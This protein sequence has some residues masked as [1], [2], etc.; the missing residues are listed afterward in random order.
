[1]PG[2][3]PWAPT[4]ALTPGHTY[5]WWVRGLSNSNVSSS[6]SSATVF[7]V[8]LL[9][10]PGLVSP[11]GSTT[12]IGVTFTWNGVGS[13]SHYYLWVQDAASGK[14]IV[15]NPNVTDT[16]Y[17]PVTLTAGRGLSSGHGIKIHS[18]TRTR[19]GLLGPVCFL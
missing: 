9:P 14:L 1:M 16:T 12:Q 3:M 5:R 11:T 19:V 7:T 10:T 6:W 13:A 17:G 8:S 2:P 18:A 15:Q 4:T